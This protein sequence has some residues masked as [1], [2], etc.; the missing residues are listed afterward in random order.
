MLSISREP[1]AM[2]GL[3]VPLSQFEPRIGIGEFSMLQISSAHF[4]RLIA[5]LVSVTESACLK[6]NRNV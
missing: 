6:C 2:R 5:P 4:P 3:S 1:T